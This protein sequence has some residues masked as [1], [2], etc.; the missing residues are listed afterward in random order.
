MNEK[1]TN[2]S[3]ILRLLKKKY[4]SEQF[5]LRHRNEWELLVATILSAQCTD[6][7][8]NRVTKKLFRK[9]PK[10]DDYVR[11]NPREFEQDI[12][13][14]GFFRNK[15]KNILTSAKKIK[16]EFAGKVPD[17]MEKLLL[18]PGVARKTAN[19]VLSQGFGKKEGIAVDTHVKRVSFRLG[20]TRHSDPEKIEQDLM[21]MV[22]QKDWAWVNTSL[23]R[24]GRETCHAR[25]PDCESCFLNRLCPGAF[26]FQKPAKRGLKARPTTTFNILFL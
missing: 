16:Q 15:T 19:I 1:K 12:H 26:R 8:V 17:S 7:R 6:Q 5:F 20:L 22:P 2:L 4:P 9:Y 10:L 25:N 14:T 11:A 13:S 24:H 3:G 21:K 18:L 23:I